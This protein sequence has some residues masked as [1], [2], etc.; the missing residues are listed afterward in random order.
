MRPASLGLRA[1]GRFVVGALFLAVELPGDG[2]DGLASRGFGEV[3]VDVGRG[4][5]RGVAQGFRD[6]GQLD[7]VGQGQGCGEVAQVVDVGA[8][9]ACLAGEVV[10][11]VEDV[12][13]VQRASVFAVE[14]ESAAGVAGRVALGFA[15]GEDGV[16]ATGRPRRCSCGSSGGSARACCCRSPR[17]SSGRR[18]C[19]RVGG[20]RPSAGRGLRLCGGRCR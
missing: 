1:G 16:N 11:V 8:R 15:A 19:V 4:G 9:D 10:E 13:R 3:A 18:R 17:G 14:D 6:D 2:I 7:A 5:D 20:R 12:L